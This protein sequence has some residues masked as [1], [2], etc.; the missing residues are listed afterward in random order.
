MTLYVLNYNNYYNRILKKFDTINE[1]ADY[2]IYTLETANFNPNDGVNT[3]HVIGAAVPYDGSGDYLLV[4][5]EFNEIVSRWFIIDGAR[6]RGGQFQL[7][8]RRDLLADF[9]DDVLNS[10]CFVEKGNLKVTDPMIFNSEDMT[11]NQIKTA[12]YL[13][14]D[15]TKTPWIVAYISKLAGADEPTGGKQ[16]EYVYDGP[17]NYTSSTLEQFEGYLDYRSDISPIKVRTSNNMRFEFGQTNYGA[18]IGENVYLDSYYV[19]VDENGTQTANGNAGLQINLRYRLNTWN[20]PATAR[21]IFAEAYANWR[22]NSTEYFLENSDLAEIKSYDNKVVRTG[23]VGEYRYY[24][25][26]LRQRTE[27]DSKALPYDTYSSIYNSIFTNSMMSRAGL[28]RTSYSQNGLIAKTEYNL[29]YLEFTEMTDQI[30]TLTTTISSTRRP[31]V[32]APYDI[33]CMP[34]KGIELG[35]D[36]LGYNQENLVIGLASYIYTALGGGSSTPNIYDVQLLPYCPVARI[37]EAMVFG[38]TGGGFVEGK[39]FNYV[40]RGEDNFNVIFYVTTA[41]FSNVIGL[42]LSVPTNSIDF[43]IANECDKYRLV[44]PNYAS[45][46]EFSAT[47][48]DGV[49]YFEVNCTYKP[50]NPYIHLNPNWSRL[51]GKDFNDGRGLVCQGDFSISSLTS[52]WENYQLQNK[53]FEQIFKREIESMELKNNISAAKD[54][55]NMFTGTASGAVAGGASGAMMSGGNPYAALGGAIAGGVASLG[56]G[57][58]DLSTN[59]VLRND[60]LD[61]AKDMY[62]Y[63]LGNIQA[64]PL[65]LTKVSS[66]DINNKIYPFVEYYTCTNVEKQALRNKIKYNGM[67]VMR[68]DTLNNFISNEESYVKGKLIRIEDTIEDYHIVNELG[69]EVNL[70]FFIKGED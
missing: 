2:I 51:Y 28:E 64:T 34:L 55:V 31:T 45:A 3:T 39:D 57:I 63:R 48:N 17:F 50:Y 26:N 4:V 62:G 32:D 5:N 20:A 11:F 21:T 30:A 38:L 47:K 40:K 42:T 65:S 36:Y 66:F 25:I 60:A 10:P 58:A 1:Y 61:Y 27:V 6:V 70:G 18:T 33:I 44:S 67:T 9:K 24:K 12:E 19:E 68:I 7:N 8:L 15:G 41:S 53:N 46:F 49:Q 16:I 14:Q 52:A 69:R 29:Y 37:Q 23:Q 54:W 59:Q 35:S 43:K 22:A 13:I 56:G